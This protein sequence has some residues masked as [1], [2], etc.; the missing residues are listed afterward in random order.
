[1][2]V[3]GTVKIKITQPIPKMKSMKKLYQ[4]ALLAAL[5]LGAV[6]TTQAQ[7]SDL[8]LGFNDAAGPAA[9]QND[10]VVD[11]G[12]SGST[13]LA[14]AAANNGT[15]TFNNIINASTFS[16]AYSAD[17]NSLTD[18][19]AGIV[20]GNTSTSPSQLFVTS[21]TSPRSP[22]STGE[23][24][25]SINAAQSSLTGEYAST[26]AGGWTQIIAASPTAAGTESSGTSLGA[27]SGNPLGLLNSG[28]IT[29]NLYEN[30]ET[31][32]LHPTVGGWVDEGTFTIDANT[33]DVTFTTA[34]VP[35]PA[36]Y[37]LLAVGGL[38]ILALRRQ[39]V[40]KNA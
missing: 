24:A 18:V 39:F 1:M 10:Y 29:L 23:F 31:G 19:A 15:Y 22:L 40:K 12:I 21:L 30:T 17:A 14:N 34:P 38:L 32:G 6:S 5:G 2:D 35:E 28:V 26:T 33:G 37:G 13:L 27:E 16:T 36:T 25:D 7:T 3:V 20:S 11:L 4:A 8:L 9:A